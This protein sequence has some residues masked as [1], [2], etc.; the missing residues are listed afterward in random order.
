MPMRASRLHGI[1]VQNLIRSDPDNAAILTGGNA[2]DGDQDKACTGGGSRDLRVER[3]RSHAVMAFQLTDSESLCSYSV[4]G[5]SASI[6]YGSARRVSAGNSGS[7]ATCVTSAAAG[8]PNGRRKNS[9]RWGSRSGTVRW[10]EVGLPLPFAHPRRIL[11]PS[12]A[13]LHSRYESR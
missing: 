4:P 11:Q 3:V 12:A 2:Q 9:A 10:S 7:A 13:S 5:D 6:L 8:P 1:R